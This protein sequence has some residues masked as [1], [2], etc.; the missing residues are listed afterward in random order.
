MVLEL[1]RST[2]TK[3]NYMPNYASAFNQDRSGW[4]VAE[5]S[6]K[7]E[8]LDTVHITGHCQNLYE[9]AVHSRKSFVSQEDGIFLR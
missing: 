2:I 6:S 7:P 1:L 3:A 4:C 8:S 5:I 9:E